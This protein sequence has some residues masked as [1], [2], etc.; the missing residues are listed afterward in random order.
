MKRV[1]LAGLLGVLAFTGGGGG[2]RPSEN[3]VPPR[4]L[5]VIVQA[6]DTAAAAAA[7]RWAGGTVRGELAIVNGVEAELTL[8]QIDRLRRSPLTRCP[9]NP[10]ILLPCSILP[11]QQ[12]DQKRYSCPTTCIAE[13]PQISPNASAIAATTVFMIGCRCRILAANCM[14]P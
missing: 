12:V 2:P 13:V 4:A 6:P 3:R 11:V 1:W 7:V 5:S 10:A 8:P 9:L 14:S